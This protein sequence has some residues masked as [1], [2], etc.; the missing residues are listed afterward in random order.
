MR[1]EAGVR[2]PLHNTHSTFTNGSKAHGAGLAETVSQI[3]IRYALGVYY[4]R[5]KVSLILHLVFTL[6]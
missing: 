1:D 2:E 4:R 3:D 6:K 5:L